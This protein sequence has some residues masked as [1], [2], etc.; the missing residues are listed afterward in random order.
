MNQKNILIFEQL[1]CDLSSTTN[2]NKEL[3]NELNKSS[4][5]Q[6]T[7][8]LQARNQKYNSILSKLSSEFLDAKL[9]TIEKEENQAAI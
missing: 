6:L 3:I 7:K 4:I 1:L 9:R 2:K 5:S 8:N